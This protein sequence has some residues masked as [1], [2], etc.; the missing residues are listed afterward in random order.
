MQEKEQARRN[1]LN[2]DQRIETVSKVQYSPQI[3]I[4]KRNPS[5]IVHPV[6][7]TIGERYLQTI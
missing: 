1:I 7:F 4:E 3:H 6:S 2:F 5:Q